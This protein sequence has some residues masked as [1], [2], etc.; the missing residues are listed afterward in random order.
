MLHRNFVQKAEDKM[1]LFIQEAIRGSTIEP[2]TWWPAGHVPPAG[3]SVRPANV[4][5]LNFSYKL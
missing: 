2:F 3:E 1:K 5:F 4:F